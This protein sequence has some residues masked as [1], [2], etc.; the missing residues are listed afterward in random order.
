MVQIKHAI[1]ILNSLT[2]KISYWN[3]FY[4]FKR[5][6]TIEKPIDKIRNNKLKLL[7]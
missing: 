2:Y 1:K 3:M 6:S 4:G 5:L 7:L